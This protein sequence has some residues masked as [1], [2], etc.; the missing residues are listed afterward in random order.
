MLRWAIG[1]VA[2]ICAISQYACDDCARE[3]CDAV[4]S[5]VA[6]APIDQGV[7]GVVGSSSD[8]CTNGCCPCEWAETTL[9]V[10]HS[11]ELVT[12][13][14]GLHLVASGDPDI[15][16]PV[17]RAYAL[18]LETGDHMICLRDLCAA[19]HIAKGD[20]FT[21]NVKLRYG[22]PSLFVFGPD[23]RDPREDLVFSVNKE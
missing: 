19:L 4:E 9:T 23:D 3:A 14:Q 11:D 16:V 15:T 12:L 21:V 8:V 1:R 6:R 7:T 20:L 10:W 18:E 13:S 5:P 22:P 2:L 17:K